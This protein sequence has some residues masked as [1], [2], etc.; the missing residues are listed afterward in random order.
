MELMQRISVYYSGFSKSE[1]KTCD[2]ILKTPSIIVENSIAEAAKIYNVSASSIVRMTKKLGY[3]GYS[4]FRYVLQA[5]INSKHET[6]N[7]SLVNKVLSIYNNA[8]NNFETY[9]DEELI[10]KFV[11]DL[12]QSRFFTIGIGNSSL[13]AKQLT[14]MFYTQKKWGECIDDAVKINY[15]A[16]N[17]QE[18]DMIIIFS[19]SANFET[20]KKFLE[21]CK[22]KKIKTTLI[23]QNSDSPLNKYTDYVFVLPTITYPLHN[24]ITPHYLENRSLFFVFI[25]IIITY[26][27]NMFDY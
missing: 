3:T 10:K 5:S 13:P 15:L 4:E 21:E 12:N 23:T 2:L 24:D 18:N 20:Y 14:Y 8:I 7:K 9:F 1:R 11:K 16:E 19:V 26:Y 27:I 25:D 6:E 22:L 17:L